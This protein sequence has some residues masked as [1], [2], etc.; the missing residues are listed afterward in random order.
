MLVVRLTVAFAVFALAGVGRSD[1]RA[2]EVP[3][4]PSRAVVLDCA[5][6]LEGWDLWWRWNY[7]PYLP[8]RT[9]ATTLP[10]PQRRDIA[11]ALQGVVETTD[12]PILIASCLLALANIGLD[13]PDARLPQ[14]F[15]RWLSHADQV[16]RER[17]A[18]ALGITAGTVDDV[19]LLAA[20]VRDDAAG[21]SVSGG[22]VTVRTR[23][24]AAYGLGLLAHRS[25]DVGSK[26]AALSEFREQIDDGGAVSE[27]QI[28]AIVGLG[29]LRPPADPAGR[30]LQAEALRVLDAFFDTA[31]AKAA[32]NVRAHVPTAIARLV[33][34]GDAAV[35]RYLAMWAPSCAVRWLTSWGRRRWWRNP[36][37]WHWASWR[38]RRRP[39]ANGARAIKP[40]VSCC[41]ICS[42]ATRIVSA[43]AS[44]CLVSVV[45]AVPAI[46]VCCSPG[47]R[48]SARNERQAGVRWRSACS[49]AI[50]LQPKP[51]LSVKR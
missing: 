10:M 43:A 32:P 16:V 34:R 48:R 44:P 49:C 21:R 17:A 15:R 20:L 51:R 25:S 8:A 30:A 14:F 36:A 41:G 42:A 31:R 26:R 37:C 1:V 46:S 47:W 29:L 6:I 28:A 45:S 19:L 22:G 33:A 35:P 24:F 11:A 27:L 3:E 38:R 23:C 40:P 7:E 13:Q 12:D 9:A 4:L 5:E 39:Q 2:Q 50:T 18:L